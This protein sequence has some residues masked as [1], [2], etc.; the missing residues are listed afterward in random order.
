MTRKD[1]SLRKIQVA[2]ATIATWEWEGEGNPILLVHATGL[3]GRCWDRVVNELPTRRV[4]A[5]DVRGHGQSSCPP[6]PYRWSHLARDVARVVEQL[7][8]EHMVGVGHSMGGNLVTRVAAELPT[9]FDRIL[10]LDPAIVPPEILA[11]IATAGDRIPPVRRRSRFASAS[12]M[13]ARLRQRDGFSRWDLRVLEDYCRH[14]LRPSPD[15]HGFELACP[16]EIEGAC[17]VGQADPDIY[18]QLR[19]IDLPVHIVRARAHPEGRF[20]PDFSYSPT[21]PN[22]VN[23]FRNA[24]ELHLTESTHFFPMEQPELVAALVSAYAEKAL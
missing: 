20:I 11:M 7:R 18:E 22:L 17:Y 13:A 23:E 15:G 14:G 8:L 2:D 4:I 19:S 10:L 16:P 9:R 12:Q 6:P 24:T 5:V 3:H 21:W 1:P